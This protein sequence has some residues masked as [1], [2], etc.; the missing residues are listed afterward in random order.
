MWRL[1]RSS[2]ER[3]APFRIK[4]GTGIN[5]EENRMAM[6]TK[7][8]LDKRLSDATYRNNK[9]LKSDGVIIGRRATASQKEARAVMGTNFFGIEEAVRF[10]G[11]K[12]NRTERYSTVPWDAIELRH[13]QST[14]VLVACFPSSI[15]DIPSRMDSKLFYGA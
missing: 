4:T 6:V 12:P 15:L 11:I 9:S 5:L 10:F 8:D 14:H 3:C 1:K 13:Y 2:C 7:S